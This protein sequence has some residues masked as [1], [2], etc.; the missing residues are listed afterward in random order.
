MQGHTSDHADRSNAMLTVAPPVI[1]ALDCRTV[2][3]K[4]LKLE[5]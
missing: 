4:N 5:R 3:Q 1:D 2:E